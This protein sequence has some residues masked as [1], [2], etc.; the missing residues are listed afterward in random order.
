[1]YAFKYSKKPFK[2]GLQINTVKNVIKHPNTNNLAYTFKEDDSYVEVRM[3]QEIIKDVNEIPARIL[4]TSLYRQHMETTYLE[5]Y[6]KQ[7]KN[8][9]KEYINLDSTE[10]IG[11]PCYLLLRDAEK[12]LE[13]R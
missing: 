12:E 2:S 4:C 7:M 11:E 13:N 8:E 5:S 10:G 9:H 6:I 1:M 3:C